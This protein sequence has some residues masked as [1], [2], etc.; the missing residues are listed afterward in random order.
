MNEIIQKHLYKI[1]QKHIYVMLQ[2]LCK[3][4]MKNVYS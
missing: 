3:C 1:I 2:L 4:L